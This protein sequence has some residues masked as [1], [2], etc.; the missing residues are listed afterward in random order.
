[1]LIL[2]LLELAPSP[3]NFS[4]LVFVSETWILSMIS[5]GR[6]FMA[7][8]PSFPKN[9]FPFTRNSFTSFPFT[10]IFPSLSIS[11]PGSSFSKASTLESGRTL[12][13]EALNSNVSFLIRIGGASLTITT[14]PKFVTASETK[15]SPKSISDV[16]F[17]YSFSQV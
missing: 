8:F 13:E 11:T 10:L 3:D 2:L 6:F 1:M 9:D 5:E 14:S 15:T 12:N 17:G 7:T 16:N 4:S